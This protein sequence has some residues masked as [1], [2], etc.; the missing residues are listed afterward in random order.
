MSTWVI[1]SCSKG[2]NTC[3]KPLRA[4][5]LEKSENQFGAS[6]GRVSWT[7]PR[8]AEVR[9]C[10][11]TVGRDV[12]ASAEPI[13]QATSSIEI[14]LTTV[15]PHGVQR[16]GRAAVDVT[17]QLPAEVGGDRLA[18]RRQHDHHHHR[19]HR[20][21][22]PGAEVVQ[23]QRQQLDGEQPAAQE[24][25]DRQ[26]TDH[27]TLPVARHGESDRG[28]D[29]Q[30][31]QDIHP[32]TL[33]RRTTPLGGRWSNPPAV[34]FTAPRPRGRAPPGNARGRPAPGPAPRPRARRSGR[35]P[36]AAPARCGAAPGRSP[37]R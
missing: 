24:A 7:P 20:G 5:T 13:S 27:E 12:P 31:I 26:H 16:A 29:Q 21:G 25:E 15:P 14:T 30:H 1:G 6:E 32:D 4:S 22:R 34:R 18:D 10:L 35:R 8:I 37:R 11:E 36:T 17:A 28:G 19:D 2:L 9:T 23:Q 3:G 33:P